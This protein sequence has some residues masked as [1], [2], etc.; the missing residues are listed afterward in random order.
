M[1]REFVNVP[2]TLE[3]ANHAV[4]AFNLSGGTARA[5]RLYLTRITESRNQAAQAVG[6]HQSLVTRALRRMTAT[7]TCGC[8]GH[9]VKM[10]LLD[11]P[12][13]EEEADAT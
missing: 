5:V 12:V 8:C 13:A 2:M 10:I 4:E 7:V 11:K 1:Q 3:D 9:P 6:V